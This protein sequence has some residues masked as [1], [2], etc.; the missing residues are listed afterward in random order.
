MTVL[1]GECAFILAVT[2]FANDS[3]SAAEGVVSPWSIISSAVDRPWRMTRATKKSL[4]V[5][6]PLGRFTGTSTSINPD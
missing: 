6:S 5:P 1:P 3:V 2:V 4:L